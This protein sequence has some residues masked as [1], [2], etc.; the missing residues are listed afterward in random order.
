MST[1]GNVTISTTVLKQAMAGI[2]EHGIEFGEKKTDVDLSKLSNQALSTLLGFVNAR[3]VRDKI[4]AHLGDPSELMD[5]VVSSPGDLFRALLP[6]QRPGR[7]A[8]RIKVG[9]RK[10]CVPIHLQH[11]TSPTGGETVQIS[12]MYRIYNVQQHFSEW[13]GRSAFVDGEGT[14]KPK[15]VREVLEVYDVEFSTEEE[16][17]SQRAAVA[18]AQ[19]IQRMNGSVRNTRG[20][21]LYR[22]RTMFGHAMAETRLGGGDKPRQLIV[23]NELEIEDG[24]RGWYDPHDQFEDLPFVRAFSLDAKQYVYVHIDDLEEHHFD[25]SGM[26]RIV[27][28]DD[29]RSI[30]T[31][32]FE[33]PTD[34][35][36]GDIFRN[37]HG[38]MVVLANGPSGVGKT[39]TAEVFAEFTERPL[40]SMEMG[41]IGTNLAQVEAALQ[42]IFER[43][44]RWNAV[45]L[46]D[47]ADIFLTKR[48]D[49]LERSAIVG[50]FL[51]LLDRYEGMFFLTTNRADVIDDAFKSRITL[52][53]DYPNLGPE[54]RMSIWRTAIAAAGVK[55]DWGSPASLAEES[56][57]GRQIRNIVRLIHA[58][59]PRDRTLTCEEVRS[60]SRYAAR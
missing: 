53:L 28:P 58:A 24:N 34:G 50:V 54:S 20:S 4:L 7:C 42:T 57:N 47:E 22:A 25:K 43:A 8:I 16:E 52:K 55:V 11:Y 26:G 36:F 37:R 15:T 44:A 27:L 40:Y 5:K 13:V 3:G 6:F 59:V 10:F 12:A 21:V 2:P 17:S 9:S 48:N 46:F 39:L 31:S 49:N 18:R 38:G 51:R 14:V 60:Y 19:P 56:L 35:V 32:V 30:L 23:E 41:E 33:A 29:M 45:L 1:N